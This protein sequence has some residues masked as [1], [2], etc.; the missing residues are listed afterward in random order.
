VKLFKPRSWVQS[1]FRLLGYQIVKIRYRGDIPY[2]MDEGFKEIFY[3]ARPFTQ[4]GVA[5]TY[6]LYSSVKYV[7]KHKIPGDIVECGV[8]KGGRLMIVA[9]TLL[10]HGETG[11]HLWLYDTYA[12]MPEPGAADVQAFDGLRAQKG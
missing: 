11:R 4:T 12:G 6:A 9:Y 10:A 8:W 5:N 7:L 3:K 1:L 2:D